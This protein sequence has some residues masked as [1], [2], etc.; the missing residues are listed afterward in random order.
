M[1]KTV[2]NIVR[3]LR[4]RRRW[5][6]QDL[7]DRA[8]TSRQIV[9]RVEHDELETVPFGTLRRVIEA[10]EARMRLDVDW[11]G[12]QLDRLIDANHARLQNAVAQLLESCGW[13]VR[14][15]VSFN[16]YG[17][18]GRYDIIA[19]HAATCWLLVVEIK[20]GIGDVQD[21]LGRLDVKVRPA[22]GVARELGWTVTRVIPML[23][24]A[25]ESS[26]RRVTRRHAALFRRFD[27]RGRA[28]AAWLRRP[29]GRPSGILFFRHL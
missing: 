18:R 22:P 20:V 15:E 21:L 5:R 8:R 11:Q 13:L 28:A 29:V 19:F 16:H 2:G 27:L 9:S 7:G 12:E 3:T 6:Q 10:L 26:S 4:R 24:I 14:V 17:D 25:E 23:A 1:R